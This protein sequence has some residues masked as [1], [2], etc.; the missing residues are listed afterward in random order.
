MTP[1][2]MSALMDELPYIDEHSALMDV[3]PD[4]GW[5][6]LVAFL[7][8]QGS[9][10]ARFAKALGCE[11]ATATPRFSGL[12]GET[13]PGFRVVDAK[14]GRRLELRGRHRFATY[15]LTFVLEDGRLT[16]R[17]HGAFPGLLGALYRLAV[18]RTG[19]HQLITRGL[20]RRIS[21]AARAL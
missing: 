1:C 5:K 2:A 3:A 8:R 4:V 13:I 15:A 19:A 16:A 11:P 20:V 9:G 6:A 17:S 7:G 14:P 21:R 12:L 10:T 18:I